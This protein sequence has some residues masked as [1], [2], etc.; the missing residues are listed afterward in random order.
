[1]KIISLAV[2][3]LGLARADGLIADITGDANTKNVPQTEL[4]KFK[5]DTFYS[6]YI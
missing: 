1:M 2:L 4:K 3:L 6:G 5:D